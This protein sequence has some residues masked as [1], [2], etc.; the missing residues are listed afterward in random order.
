[1]AAMGQSPGMRQS[2]RQTHF[3]WRKRLPGN[4][5]RRQ[6]LLA[7]RVQELARV[8]GVSV[9]GRADPPR[10]LAERLRQLN[11]NLKALGERLKSSIASVIGSTIAEAVKTVTLAVGATAYV[12]GP[13]LAAWA[14]ILA[15]VASLLLTADAARSAVQLAGG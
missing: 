9:G 13:T 15:S 2:G 10:T 7:R 1:M 3:F 5:L 12:A 6:S 4:R 8:V 14:G 11:D